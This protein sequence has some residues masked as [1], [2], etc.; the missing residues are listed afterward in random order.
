MS[1]SGKDIGP[2]RQYPLKDSDYSTTPEGIVKGMTDQEAKARGERFWGIE[3][4]KGW[5]EEWIT[6]G[7]EL[8]QRK[9]KGKKK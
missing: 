1:A 3:G 6:V 7:A 4:W 8:R 9:R 2:A 5:R